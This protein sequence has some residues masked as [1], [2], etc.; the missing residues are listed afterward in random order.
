M[1][2]LLPLHFF[3]YDKWPR[4]AMMKSIPVFKDMLTGLTAAARELRFSKRMH[5]GR[6]PFKIAVDE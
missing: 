2:N 5:K 3:R 6:L 4:E 1:Q